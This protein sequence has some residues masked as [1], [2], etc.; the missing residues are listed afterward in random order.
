MLTVLD[1]LPVYNITHAIRLIV[2]HRVETTLTWDQLR[3]PQVSQFLV[4]PM[5]QQIRT[6]HFSR[7][8]LYA[9]MANCLQ[10]GKEAQMNPGNAGTSR[11]RAMVCEL[12]AIK[13]LKEYSTRELIDALSYDFYPLQGLNGTQ[14][15]S[16]S[17]QNSG[18][19]IRSKPA[20]ARLSTLEVAIRAL[21]KHFLAHP[22]TVRQLEAIW[23]GT[24]VFHSAAD[25]LHRPPPRVTPAQSRDY[26]ITD[27][28]TRA[29]KDS[30]STQVST[31]RT[32]TL[33]DPREASLFKL[34]R[35]RVPRYRQFFSTCS[36]AV[37][38]GLYLA[39]LRERSM[40]IT[41]LEVIFWFWSAG[42]ILDE[43]V[44][45]NEQGFSL[46]IMSVWNSFDLGILLLLIIFYCMRL[47]GMFLV[48]P[49][50]Y[51]DWNSLA[52]DVLGTNAVLLFP[53]LFNMLDNFRYFS[54][55]L[56]AF[57]LMAMDLIAVLILIIISCSGFFVAFTLSFGNDDNDAADVAYG[58]FQ[59]VLG[60]TPAA[61]SVWD[62]YNV[63]G[64]AILTLFLFITHFLII[65]VLL[66][67]LT[68]SFMAIASNANEE[69]Q[70]VS[71]VNTISMVKND[72]LFSYVA[73]SNILAWFI[74][75][76]RLILPFRQFVKLNRYVIKL[77][78][79]P[80][81]F[82]IFAYEKLFLA[83]SVYV[84]TDL[85]E[86]RGR[87]R[88]RVISFMEPD[89]M[90]FFSPSIR[91][92]QESM[93]GFQKDRALDEVFRLVP[94]REQRSAVMSQERRETSNVV[95][96]WM[97]QY[98]G[99]ASSPAEQDRS[100]VERLERQRQAS[101]RAALLRQDRV[102]QIAGT[103]SDGSGPA[104]RRPPIT[105]PNK[106]FASPLSDRE[107]PS[108]SINQGIPETDDDG[109]DELVTNEED[110]PTFDK[111]S[112]GDRSN[113]QE[114]DYFLYPTA[115][116]PSPPRL[117]TPSRQSPS[118]SKLTRRTH[119]RNLSTN[120]VLYNP[121]EPEKAKSSSSAS[122]PKAPNKRQTPSGSGTPKR[123]IYSSSKPR[124]IMPNRSLFQSAP[125]RPAFNL[126]SQINPHSQRQL[127]QRLSSVDL[128][129][130]LTSD[131]GIP[132]P[133]PFAAVPAS[134]ATQMAMATGMVKNAGAGNDGTDRLMGRLMLAKMK[135]LE[136][137]LLE[138]V[139]EFKEMRTQG[140][141][142]ADTGDDKKRDKGKK[143]ARKKKE[144]QRPSSAAGKESHGLQGTPE[145]KMTDELRK[146]GSSL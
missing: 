84:P 89:R 25:Q 64:K 68:N 32:V 106:D 35:L 81:L 102:G 71:A 73:P 69:H 1:A 135:T 58:L 109:D 127:R 6:A 90:G 80:L 139:R 99:I 14:P 82:A 119:N 65:T 145:D 30:Q 79:F 126:D 4:K 98:E 70:F 41:T 45:F 17:R 100:I 48:D 55:L 123:S 38:L 110:N 114:E 56:I 91:I 74:T 33:Y 133:N 93:S 141:S 36:L 116:R 24:I 144:T 8:T 136:E 62:G 86:K 10:F 13:L 76:L 138:V 137:G 87:E 140:N 77:T 72:A 124:P 7:A 39:V 9:L 29:S 52:F 134:F 61:W 129:A 59:M 54:Q 125:S 40:S 120:T 34:S 128:G 101:Q 51:E 111:S 107:V 19:I 122:P 108:I 43:I 83:R 117:G 75:P 49:E 42:F 96:N 103:R 66:T 63:L 11:T 60:F 22:V 95:R 53:R 115:A 27:P 50:T 143:A 57:R 146:K 85:I 78:H 46:Y 21:A 118:K 28:T 12:L 26:G 37:L 88:Q 5:Q 121:I 131:L 92:R 2:L 16:I 132:D 104:D 20:A 23:A 18:D 31:R 47:Y 130:D 44:G 67:V 3:A 15:P 142:P 94:R 105:R 113:I 112:R 97:E